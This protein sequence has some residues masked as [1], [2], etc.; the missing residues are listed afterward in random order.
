MRVIVRSRGTADTGVGIVVTRRPLTVLVPSH[1]ITLVEQSRATEIVV[2]GT[3]FT[4]FKVLATPS[5]QA[6]HLS[7]L[8]FGRRGSGVPSQVR[9]PRRLLPLLAGQDV[10]L[11]SAEE[12]A[13]GRPGK[14]VGI[15]DSG[16]GVSIVT[17]I[18]I[19]NGDSGSAIIASGRFAAICQGMV[20][21]GGAVA[22]PLSSEGL[23][24]LRH[25]RARARRRAVIGAAAAIAAIAI[26]VGMLGHFSWTSFRPVRLKIPEDGSYVTAHNAHSPSARPTWTRSFDT[27]IR[28]YELIPGEVGEDPS[29]VAIG[30]IPQGESNGAFILLNR[31]GRELWRT[32][33]A[34]G[35]CIYSSEEEVFDRYLVNDIQYADLDLDGVPELLVVFV[36]DHFFPCKFVVLSLGGETLA[37]YWHPGYFRTFTVGAMPEG[38]PPLVVITGSNNAIKTSWWN[39]QTLFAF[40]GLAISGQAP[41]Y[42]GTN[43]SPEAVAPGSE[44]WYR[45]FQHIEPEYRRPKCYKIDIVAD[46]PSGEQAIRAAVADSRFYYV[47]ED[48]R[49][50][51]VE[52]GDQFLRDYPGVT[53]PPL[54]E[55]P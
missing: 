38:E 31:E 18:E 10:C 1:L 34:D 44:L 19:S 37:E 15:Q 8:R 52:L 41:P 2:H 23:A 40:R 51:H 35:E 27:P 42:P 50:L 28:R 5:L 55:L 11:L 48:G 13:E 24:E 53:P 20:A 22:V 6:D 47:D 12:A 30:T 43:G 4:Q 32:S 46:G 45:V 14:V 29:Y 16:D 7:L 25:V 54:L 49:Q 9:L 26:G 33:V 3:S 21:G 36:H 39:P 17:D